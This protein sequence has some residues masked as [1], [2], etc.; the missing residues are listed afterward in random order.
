MSDLTARI[1]EH[2]IEYIR[3]QIAKRNSVPYFASNKAV[4]NVVTDMDHHPYTRWFRGVYY[5]PDPIIMEREAGWR[6][7]KDS[8]YSVNSPPVIE[9]NPSHC[10]ESA[11]STIFPCI[12]SQSRY[13]DRIVADT[14][15]NKS[16]IVKN[17]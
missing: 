3:S 16:C 5:Y 8:C 1:N 12:P 9:E 14:V 6:P 10:F 4:T 2:S 13:A 7:R 17:Y 15:I 11:C